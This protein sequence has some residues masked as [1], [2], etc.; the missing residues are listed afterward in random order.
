MA[1]HEVDLLA[2]VSIAEFLAILVLLRRVLRFG[3]ARQAG[4]VA[5]ILRLPVPEAPGGDGGQRA[6]ADIPFDPRRYAA[7]LVARVQ[8]AVEDIGRASCRERVWQDV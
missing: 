4:E 1:D 5:V 3:H 8:A 2:F 6:G 7:D